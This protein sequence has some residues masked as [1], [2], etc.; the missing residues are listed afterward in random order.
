M[1]IR[2]E[3]ES[4]VCRMRA[5][6][7]TLYPQAARTNGLWSGAGTNRESQLS[8]LNVSG[9]SNFKP[10]TAFP[11]LPALLLRL[12]V[13]HPARIAG[14]EGAHVHAENEDIDAVIALAGHWVEWRV[15]HVGLFRVPR[16]DPRL[17]AVLKFRNDAVREFLHRIAGRGVAWAPRVPDCCRLI[18]RHV[19]PL[20]V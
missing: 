17:Q 2:S 11:D 9:R 6:P 8:L 14:L 13:G 16:P 10:V 18:C 7:A 4:N 5:V 20:S 15:Q 19:L 3:P 1:G 12:L